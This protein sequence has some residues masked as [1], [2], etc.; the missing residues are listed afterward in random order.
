MNITLFRPPDPLDV[1]PVIA[2]SADGRIQRRRLE[3]H[4]LIAA[5]R[6]VA[7][8]RHR[9]EAQLSIDLSMGEALAVVQ[10]REFAAGFDAIVAE[11]LEVGL[12]EE[13]PRA[14]SRARALRGQKQDE[15]ARESRRACSVT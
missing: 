6:R 10:L 15:S 1:R 12:R 3:L 9:Q 2:R 4:E 7:E 14:L 5:L 13:P 11:V 8:E